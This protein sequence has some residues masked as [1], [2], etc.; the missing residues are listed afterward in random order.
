M[1]ILKTVL[2][3]V[4][5]ETDILKIDAAICRESW[6]KVSPVICHPVL[7]KKVAMRA[8]VESMAVGIFTT[9]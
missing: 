3:C 7:R 1:T 9:L 8:R 4:L 6:N 2:Y 5:N